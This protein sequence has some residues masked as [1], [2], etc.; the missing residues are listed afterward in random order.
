MLYNFESRDDDDDENERAVLVSLLNS[1]ISLPFKR[2]IERPPLS[3]THFS[4]L[5][6]SDEGFAWMSIRD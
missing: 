5:R 4:G 1:S 2:S 6:D 3:A